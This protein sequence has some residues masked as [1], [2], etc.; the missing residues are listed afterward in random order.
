[1]IEGA[2]NK[3]GGEE[4]LVKKADEKPAA[5]MALLGKCLPRD[6]RL[7]GGLQLKINLYKAGDG[8]PAGD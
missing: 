5:F 7:G 8:R 4:W 2:L 3:L 1:M 6:V